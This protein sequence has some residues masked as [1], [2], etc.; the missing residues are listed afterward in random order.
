MADIDIKMRA[1]DALIIMNTAIK[2]VLLYPPTSATIANTI[3]K[4]YMIFLDLLEQE[5]PIVFAESEK[6]V[7]ICGIPLEQKDQARPPVTAF[8]KILLNFGIRSISFGKGL[9]NEELSAFIE[10]LSKKPDVVRNEGDLPKIMA[11]KNILHIYLDQKV[12]VSMDKDQ[13]IISSLDIKDGEITQFLMSTHPELASDPQKLQEMMKNPEWLLEAFQAGLSQIMAQKGTLSNQQLSEKLKNLLALVDK[14]TSPLDQN[15]QENILQNLGKTIATM[16]NEIIQELSSQEIEQLFGGM[17]LQYIMFSTLDEIKPEDKSVESNM[18]NASTFGGN[19]S[20]AGGADQENTDNQGSGSGDTGGSEKTGNQGSGSGDTAGSEKTGNQGSGS[21]DTAGSEKTGNQGSGS[22]NTAGSE[23][24]DYQQ[25]LFNLKE[26]LLSRLKDNSRPFM[27]APL[28]LVLPKII[29]QLIAQ[30]EQETMEKIIGRLMADL[31]NE[32]ADVRAKASKGL[33]EIIESFSPDRQSELIERLSGQLID[34]IKLETVVTLDYRTICRSLQKLLQAFIRQGRF[35]ETIPIMD[36]FNDIHARILK[37]NDEI[38]DVS[39]EIIQNLA[40]EEYIS[41]LFKEFHT[42]EGNKRDE[43]GQI[44]VRFGDVILDHLLD[45][46]HEASDG[47]ERVNIMHII[48]GMGQKAIPAIRNQINNENA[49]WYYLRNM[50]FLLGRIGNETNAYMLQPLLLHEDNR[51]RS[52]ALK[53]I[54][55]IGGKQRGPLL[56]SALPKADD[57]FKLNIIETLGNAKCAEAV[58]IFLDLLKKRS[59]IA[60]QS[61]IDMQE[62]ICIALGLIGSSGA[63]TA[64]SEIVESKSFLRIRAYPEKVKHAAGRALKSIK[65]KQK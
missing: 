15:D 62:K 1:L 19:S 58:P 55:Q 25:Q 14:V 48:I 40:S 11:E 33:T 63:I 12:Y 53:S 36:V 50:A 59:L 49:A 13:E 60:S 3:E 6:N 43:A 22:G 46:L 30:K 23:K 35:T 61:Q 24:I 56:L 9:E 4:L 41:I 45:I 10:L 54:F 5:A 2:N 7:L 26:K 29:E 18:S 47:K 65:I 8:L 52:E 38:R 28:L 21:G 51:V 20:S 31:L 64:L 27:D 44:L 42:N 39:S 17:L 16:D 32:D 37:K 57:Q 34:W